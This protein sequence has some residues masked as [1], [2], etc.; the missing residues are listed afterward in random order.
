MSDDFEK[1]C[2]SR[3]EGW[4]CEDRKIIPR[5]MQRIYRRQARRRLKAAD[6]KVGDE[7]VAAR[8]AKEKRHD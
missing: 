6:R 8:A 7:V 4:W 3:Y 5:A 2:K 1:A